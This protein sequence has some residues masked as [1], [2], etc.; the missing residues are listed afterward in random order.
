MKRPR[1]QPWHGQASSIQPG[2]PPSTL[3]LT[4]VLALAL[5]HQGR[6]ITHLFQAPQPETGR[7][8]GHQTRN[9]PPV[10]RLSSHGRIISLGICPAGQAGCAA[11]PPISGA[12][13]ASAV[14]A[15]PVPACVLAGRTT[16]TGT[17]E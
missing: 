17:L 1:T 3:T 10:A 16:S 13:D 11:A 14:S 6:G 7:L 12:V 8:N 5:S 15:I 9:D 2:A 4:L